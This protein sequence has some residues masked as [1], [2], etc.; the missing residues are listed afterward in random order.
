MS[1]IDATWVVLLLC[2]LYIVESHFAHSNPGHSCGGMAKAERG[3]SAICVLQPEN[4]SGVGGVVAMH[5]ISPIHPIYYEFAVGGL[6]LVAHHGVHIHE[7]GD[8]T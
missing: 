6:G 7:W 5:Q 8:L 1:R 2:L 3:R 4:N